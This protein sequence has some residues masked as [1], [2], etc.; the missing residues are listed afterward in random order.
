MIAT[1]AIPDG[2]EKSSVVIVSSRGLDQLVEELRY[3]LS[4]SERT[5]TSLEFTVADRN[6]DNL[7]EVIRYV[8]NGSAGDPLTRRYN[9]GA[10]IRV[11]ESIQ[12]FLF[13]YQTMTYQKPS[14]PR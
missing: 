7:Q 13:D 6:G 1:H 8:W 3:A 2:T 14:P 4:I 10:L 5:A 9:G 11:A 12:N